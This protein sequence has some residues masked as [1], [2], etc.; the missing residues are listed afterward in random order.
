MF[1]TIS[2]ICLRLLAYH[3]PQQ[4]QQQQHVNAI[5]NNMNRI[6][7][8]NMLMETVNSLSEKEQRQAA[9][10]IRNSTKIQPKKGIVYIIDKFLF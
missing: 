10:G 3:H 6:G 8:M 1:V 7:E 4:Q 2:L 9:A 5:N